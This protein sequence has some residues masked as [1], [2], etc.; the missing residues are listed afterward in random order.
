MNTLI[1]EREETLGEPKKI[2]FEVPF[3]QDIY[4]FR[5]TCIR[6]AHA[7]GYHQNSVTSAFGEDDDTGDSK[8]LK[9][10]LG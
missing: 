5:R 4:D 3:D 7:L 8:Q 6:M 1:Y 9:L 2:I 10:I